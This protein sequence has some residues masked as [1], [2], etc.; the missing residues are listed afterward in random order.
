MKKIKYFCLNF[1]PQNFKIKSKNGWIDFFTPP[2]I[3]PDKKSYLIRIP[4]LNAN[5]NDFFTQIAKVSIEVLNFEEKKLSQKSKLLLISRQVK[6]S[7]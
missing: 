7:F 1:F 2:L 5:K 6:P 4:E 3:T